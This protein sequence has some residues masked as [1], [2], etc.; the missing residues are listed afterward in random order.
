MGRV[1]YTSIFFRRFKKFLEILIAFHI[2]VSSFAPFGH[3]FTME[4]EYVEESVKE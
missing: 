3:G 2:L 4:D 1:T